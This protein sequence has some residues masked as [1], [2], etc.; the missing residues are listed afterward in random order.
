M[1]TF[2]YWQKQNCVLP[3]RDEPWALA[4]SCPLYAENPGPNVI[5][6]LWIK[7]RGTVPQFHPHAQAEGQLLCNFSSRPVAHLFQFNLVR[8]LG[9]A[10]TD[11]CI[12]VPNVAR[13]QNFCYSCNYCSSRKSW[14]KKPG[15]LYRK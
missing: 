10:Q 7:T 2:T 6:V 12:G 3:R 5:V 15:T 8:T 1:T 13:G 4:A 14:F 9:L 11:V